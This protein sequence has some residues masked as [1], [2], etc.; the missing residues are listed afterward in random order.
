MHCLEHILMVTA[1]A[2]DK[3]EISK[4]ELVRVLKRLS[5]SSGLYIPEAGDEPTGIMQMNDEW[6][7]RFGH[8]IHG[9]D[10]GESHD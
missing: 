9:S 2:V 1:E 10:L 5:G 3:D 7:L 6:H 4:A 8:L